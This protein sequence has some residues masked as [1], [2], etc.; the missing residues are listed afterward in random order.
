MERPAL[1]AIITAAF[2]DNFKLGSVTT[3][4]IAYK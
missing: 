2:S 1:P 4:H 3:Q